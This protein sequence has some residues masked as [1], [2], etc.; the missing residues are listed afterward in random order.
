VT[1]LTGRGENSRRPKFQ[2]LTVTISR[3]IGPSSHARKDANVHGVA[4]RRAARW[5]AAVRDSDDD[6]EEI[7]EG[8]VHVGGLG[9]R[10]RR[11][12]IPCYVRQLCRAAELHGANEF[13]AQ[14]L[15]RLPYP[16]G[17]SYGEAPEHRPADHH[18]VGAER[19]GLENV[20]AAPDAAI[21]IDF[22]LAGQGGR[23]LADRSGGRHRGIKMT[24]AVIGD[25]DCAGTAFD[26]THGIVG[27][28]NQRRAL[29]P[30]DGPSSTD[31]VDVGLPDQGAK[32]RRRG[33]DLIIVCATWECAELLNKGLVPRPLD[34]L[35]HAVLALRG[36]WIGAILFR[37][38]FALGRDP[39]T[40]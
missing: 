15:E 25:Y 22:G 23:H 10:P 31:G 35:D 24:P 11:K 18:G 28:L 37:P 34:Q 16:I 26:A 27:A 17:S 20:R 9:A 33:V 36:E 6:G 14:V 21:D 29:A 39:V 13:D 32:G 19:Q 4:E 30:A 12:K 38:F 5:I 3:S 8:S 40:L 7:R 1:G 2:S